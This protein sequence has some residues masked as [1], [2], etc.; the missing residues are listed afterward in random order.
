[1]DSIELFKKQ[2]SERVASNSSNEGLIKSAKNFTRESII[3]KYTYNFTW[4]GR[5]II[6]YPQDVIALQEIIWRTKPDLI[7]ETGIAHGG[8]L[9]FFA[10]MLEMI[11][12]EEAYVLGVDI[13]IREHNKK[14]ILDHP[15]S[16][17]IKMLEGSS[18]SDD[19]MNEVKRIAD[20]KSKILVVL[21]SYHGHDHVLKEL[22][23][24]APLVSLN[25]YCVVFDTYI[26]RFTEVFN[27]EYSYH[28]W[29]GDNPHTAVKEFL[30]GNA[31]FEID[32]NIQDKLLI[33]SA[34]NGYL[35]RVQ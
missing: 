16:K 8:S 10:S 17:K 4:L 20:G 32:T 33:T 24:Y 7:I 15:M 1:M 14:E 19:V 35:K 29:D 9:I 23:L 25:S 21:D 6:Q 26:E 31:D 22:K 12:K 11:G 3:S 18:V 2:C 13:D 28:S 5:P 34:P 27:K 30:R